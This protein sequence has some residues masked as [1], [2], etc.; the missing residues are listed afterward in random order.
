LIAYFLTVLAPMMIRVAVIILVL[1]W[2]TQ[3]KLK[4]RRKV[5]LPLFA[6]VTRKHTFRQL[7]Q[8]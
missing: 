1:S 4:S 7:R 2:A 8:G 5:S 6:V 3:Q